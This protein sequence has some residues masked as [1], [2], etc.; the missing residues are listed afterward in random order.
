MTLINM[1]PSYLRWGRSN[2]SF[3]A[4]SPC[5]GPGAL[6][7]THT[8][9]VEGSQRWWPFGILDTT[10]PSAKAPPTIKTQRQ[11]QRDEC[12][13]VLESLDHSIEDDIALKPLRLLDHSLALL[14]A[15]MLIESSFG[16][17]REAF[18]LCDRDID[19]GR[20]SRTKPPRNL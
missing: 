1:C 16:L 11:T 15:L 14:Q 4:I 6:G 18:T 17:P 8:R 12:H 13:T 2:L 9:T 20:V 19:M 5:V 3:F 10:A 7:P